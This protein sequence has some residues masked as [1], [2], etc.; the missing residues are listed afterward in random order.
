MIRGLQIYLMALKHNFAARMAYR[1][2]FMFSSLMSFVSEMFIP[3][4][5]F[6][7]YE[8][9]SSFPG[10]GFY[11][12]LLLQGIFM[13]SNG[14]ARLTFFGIVSSTLGHVREGTYDLLLIKPRSTL[15]LSI[16]NVFSPDSIGTIFAA[17]YIIR[18]SLDK[19][20]WPGALSWIKF[21]VLFLFSLMVLFSFSLFM[22]GSM[23]KWVGNSRIYE[24]FD[25]I[26]S[27]GNYPATIFS[28]F[29]RILISNVIPI[30]LLGFFPASALLGKEI[31]GALPAALVCII[32]LAL[33][34]CFWR[35]MLSK[36]TSAGG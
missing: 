13:L 4:I 19:L 21:I 25:S 15:F 1:A 31:D 20:V 5:T 2:D 34:F 36:Y 6:F 18:L 33:G 23:F 28:K 12:V 26:T 8:M 29:F 35:F 10:W 3:L 17:V 27:F 14:V 30:A 7:I 32:F 11:E 24:I 16:A 22:A 9:G